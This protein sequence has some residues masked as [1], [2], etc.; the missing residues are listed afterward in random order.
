MSYVPQNQNMFSSVYSAGFAALVDR[1][2]ESVIASPTAFATL[3]TVAGAYAQ[4]F[5]TNW[6][7]TADQFDVD[8]AKALS[9]LALVKRATPQTLAALQTPNNW[10]AIA[11]GIIA[12]ITAG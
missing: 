10:D 12:A 1:Y 2:E 11:E 9:C 6:G 4:S 7:P 3:A 5:D 8:A